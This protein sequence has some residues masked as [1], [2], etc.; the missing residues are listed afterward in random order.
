MHTKA[1]FRTTQALCAAG[2]EV[3]RFNFRGVGISTG[4]FGGGIAEEEDVEAALDWLEKR[5]P[6]LPLLVAG[7][8]FGSRVGLAVGVHDSRVKGL[9]GLGLPLS[10]ADFSWLEDS[11]KPLLVVQGEED[12]FASGADVARLLEGVKGDVTL[13]RIDDSDHYFHDRFEELQDSVREYFTRGPGSEAFPE[14]D[15]HDLDDT[16][17]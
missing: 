7:F 16:S 10:I 5:Y 1:V 4:S 14:L 17:N 13:V 11:G 12:E 8:S 6:D 3:L 2:F 9:L 15:D